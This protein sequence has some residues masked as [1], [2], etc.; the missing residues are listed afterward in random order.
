MAL[1]DNYLYFETSLIGSGAWTYMITV[2]WWFYFGTRLIIFMILLQLAMLLNLLLNLLWDTGS[3]GQLRCC[4]LSLRRYV[5]WSPHFKLR[6]SSSSFKISRSIN[7]CS[8]CRW[9]IIILWSEKKWF[10]IVPFL[11]LKHSFGVSFLILFLWVQIE[12]YDIKNLKR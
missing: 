9:T 4:P 11:F 3:C 1:L 10:M 5:Y 2:Y 6:A 12:L 7:L 8:S